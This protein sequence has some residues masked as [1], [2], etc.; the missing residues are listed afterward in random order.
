MVPLEKKENTQ[1]EQVYGRKIELRFGD[2]MSIRNAT[3]DVEITFEYATLKSRK[4]IGLK[5][6]IWE[7]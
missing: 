3:E 1:E 7:F 2:K 5:I 4:D 6:L